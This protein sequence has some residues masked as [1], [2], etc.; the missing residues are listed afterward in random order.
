MAAVTSGRRWGLSGGRASQFRS[1]HEEAT[2]EKVT[3]FVQGRGEGGAPGLGL[4]LWQTEA[5][6]HSGP[7]YPALPGHPALAHHAHGAAF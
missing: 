1:P 7:R 4:V 5:S 6:G 2:G 3:G